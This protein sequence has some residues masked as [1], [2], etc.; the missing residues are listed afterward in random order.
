MDKKKGSKA[1]I[2]DYLLARKGSGFGAV[3]NMGNVQIPTLRGRGGQNL[4][5][6]IALRRRDVPV[7]QCVRRLAA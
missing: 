1:L 2:L 4:E 7:G 5:H 6:R 3:T